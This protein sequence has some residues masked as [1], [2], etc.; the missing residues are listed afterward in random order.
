MND[1][2]T[3][4]ASEHSVG[5]SQGIGDSISSFNV[6]REPQK[7]EWNTCVEKNTPTE[8]AAAADQNYILNT[9]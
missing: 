4:P 3:Y 5:A 1:P 8:P 7:W 2:Q 6:G 9:N